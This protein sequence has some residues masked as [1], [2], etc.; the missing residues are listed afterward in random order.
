MLYYRKPG[1]PGPASI[2]GT[3]RQMTRLDTLAAPLFIIMSWGGGKNKDTPLLHTPTPS[4]K[5]QKRWE[6]LTVFCNPTV[7]SSTPSVKCV[8]MLLK[9]LREARVC[10]VGRCVCF[11]V[12]VRL[13]R[14]RPP[15]SQP[16]LQQ[17]VVHTGPPLS[18]AAPLPLSKPAATEIVYAQRGW[19]TPLTKKGPSF[20]PTFDFVL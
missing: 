8:L 15:P 14:V 9:R 3:S 6:T 13:V 7:V 4:L 1:H 19:R 11:R 12:C 17:A 2:T 20:S 16:L 5:K 10:V 18:P